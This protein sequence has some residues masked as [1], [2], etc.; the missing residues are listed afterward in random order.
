[1]E[2]YYSTTNLE[3]FTGEYYSPEVGVSYSIQVEENH[4]SVFRNKEKIK[5]LSLVSKNV[6]GN[7][8]QG[9]QF[10]ET[11]GKITG[12]L[13][14]DRRVRNLKFIKKELSKVKSFSRD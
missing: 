1:M 2:A 14:Q 12:F 10:T 9:Y 5:T 7:H 11:V 4:L 13:M 6:F 3:A 8:F